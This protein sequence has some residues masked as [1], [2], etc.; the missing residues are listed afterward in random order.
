MNKPPRKKYKQ[1]LATMTS[2]SVVA[3]T[4][5]VAVPS[6]TAL[7]QTQFSDI[8]EARE[9][10][11]AIH[12]LV[13]L[14]VIT[15]YPDGTF[16]PRVE[17]T[18]QQAAVMFTRA[19]NLD[20]R[21]VKDPGFQDIALSHQY[22]NEIAAAVEAGFFN[23][24]GQFN[25]GGS[26][27]RAQ[28]ATVIA[29]AF[30]L[31][32]NAPYPFSDNA[33]S[34]TSNVSL[35]A[36]LGL[37]NGYSDGT[38]RPNQPL[39]REH[40]A[41]LMHRTIEEVGLPEP[42]KQASIFSIE[43]DQNANHSLYLSGQT[44]G[45]REVVI[46]VYRQDHR[47]GQPLVEEVVSVDRAGRFELV[48]DPLE[49]GTYVIVVDG[50]GVQ[51]EERTYELSNELL[52]RPGEVTNHNQPSSRSLGLGTPLNEVFRF[53][54]TAGEEEI[55]LRSTQLRQ[56]GTAHARD[57]IEEVYLL[58]ENGMVITVGT[59]NQDNVVRLS[60]SVRIPE[61]TTKE[62]TVAVSLEAHSSAIT[63][64]VQFAIE[65]VDAFTANTKLNGSFPIVGNSFSIV[66]SNVGTLEVRGSNRRVDVEVG[67]TQEELG[68]FTLQPSG[69]G[70]RLEKVII[71]GGN[72]DVDSFANL[73]LYRSNGGTRIPVQG[74]ADREKVVFDLKEEEIEI[75]RSRLKRLR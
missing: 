33:G 27:T 35:M 31:T 46:R 64:T 53:Q 56:L 39:Y 10:Y 52:G 72:F 75:D 57:H 73:Y 40:F 59:V 62:F 55:Q 42:S 19:F 16:R 38:F 3:S 7:A 48:T 6:D 70:V 32:G 5:F 67:D 18:R 23:R 24:G 63:A 61:H 25:P 12:E 2:A 9:S 54:V 71:Y 8:S 15:G 43:L 58:D 68:E 17:I 41:M 37:I 14:G 44:E 47:A 30:N 34:H 13:S 65:S 4:V 50:E 29:R 66:H 51:A 36:N 74:F 45:L 11:Q 20:T 69:E 28:A 26:F 49:L 1:F 22:Y 21:N 60:R